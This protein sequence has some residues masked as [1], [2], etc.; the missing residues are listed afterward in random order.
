LKDGLRPA[1]VGSPP[2]KTP[3][4]SKRRCLLWAGG[5]TRCN[6]QVPEQR[7]GTGAADMSVRM[8]K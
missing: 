5:M 4:P 7:T 6:G 2:R 3:P 8:I 1:A